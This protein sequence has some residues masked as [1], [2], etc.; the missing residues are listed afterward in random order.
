M[1]LDRQAWP[2][3]PWRGAGILLEVQQGA[4]EQ[5]FDEGLTCS[6]LCF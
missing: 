4:I 6:H 5:V 3:G 1:R 2:L